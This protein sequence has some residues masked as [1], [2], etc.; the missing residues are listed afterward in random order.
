[1]YV[2]HSEAPHPEMNYMLRH[3]QDAASFFAMVSCGTSG[4]K[5]DSTSEGREVGKGSCRVSGVGD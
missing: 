4:Y 3:R 2:A 1:M 5:E